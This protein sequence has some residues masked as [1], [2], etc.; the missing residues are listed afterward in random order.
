MDVFQLLY[1]IIPIYKHENILLDTGLCHPY[2]T[3]QQ[4]EQ[5]LES[6]NKIAAHIFIKAEHVSQMKKGISLLWPCLFLFCVYYYDATSHHSYN[7]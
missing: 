3:L 6:W 1:I 2:Y 4:L 7:F 5:D